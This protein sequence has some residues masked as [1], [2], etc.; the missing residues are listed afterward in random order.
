MKRSGT[1]SRICKIC[2]IE[3]PF[4]RDNVGAKARGFMGFV[5]Y[6]CHSERARKNWQDKHNL[7]HLELENI[8]KGW[9]I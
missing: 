8:V 3:G 2:S 9:L 4:Y 1:I 5:C 6:E 7:Q